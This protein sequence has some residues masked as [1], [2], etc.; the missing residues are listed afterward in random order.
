M[1][2]VRLLEGRKDF[3][4][5][6]IPDPAL[7]A[8]TV[9]ARVETAFLHVLRIPWRRVPSKLGNVPSLRGSAPSAWVE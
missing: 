7:R 8:E 6:D 3:V 5:E 1:K 2:A 9:V 4:I